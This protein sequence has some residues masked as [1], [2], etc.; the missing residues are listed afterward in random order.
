MTPLKWLLSLG[1]LFA[2]VVVGAFYLP[3][4][5]AKS[6]PLAAVIAEKESLP[7][8][9]QAFQAAKPV[10]R[11]QEFYAQESA[12]IGAVDPNPELTQKRL[13]L[14]A[15][16]LEPAEISWLYGEA[17]D[18]K[19]GGDGRFFATYLLALSG[20]PESL[21]ALGKIA[22]SPVP[23]NKNRGMVELDRQLRAQ[24]TEGL[25][26]SCA[27]NPAAKDGLLDVVEKQEDEFLRDR[28]HR[29]LY[30]CRTG[31]SVEEQDQEGLNKLLYKK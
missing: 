13:E 27:A 28:A 18:E 14:V 8:D 21:V 5:P 30:Q 4:L 17:M 6:V 25:G 22:V 10:A 19:R 7:Q 26:R 15:K 24:A 20:N 23:P 9:V 16:E 2:L 11:V 3:P 1:L 29:A 31:K 12:R